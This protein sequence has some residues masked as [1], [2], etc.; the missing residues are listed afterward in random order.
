MCVN[1]EGFSN[2][3][4]GY[5]PECGCSVYVIY[6]CLRIF[7]FVFS[8]MCLIKLVVEEEEAKQRKIGGSPDFEAH[9][10]L[11][12]PWCGDQRFSWGRAAG[13]QR[14][15]HSRS[16]WSVFERWSVDTLTLSPKL[17]P[18]SQ[19]LDL[20]ESFAIG[21]RVQESAG[22]KKQCDCFFWGV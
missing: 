21:E 7:L 19:A 13:P 9:T 12:R 6:S 15:S 16:C 14:K 10:A 3:S 2:F 4:L 1:L 17:S 8:C 22:V 11:H 20:W 5:V 18:C